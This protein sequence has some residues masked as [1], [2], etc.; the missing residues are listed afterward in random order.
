MVNGFRFHTIDHAQ[1][2]STMNYGVCVRSSCYNDTEYDF[3]GLL[4]EILEFQYCNLP[5]MYVTL[6]KCRWVD[7]VTGQRIH[8]K[9]GFVDV[10]LSRIYKTDEPFV[11]VQQATQVYYVG[12]PGSK[13]NRVDWIAA[14]TTKARSTVEV[15]WSDV[16]F[17]P[18]N[19]CMRGA[20]STQLDVPLLHDPSGDG[21]HIDS[22]ED[23]EADIHSTEGTDS[24]RD[25]STDSSPSG[26]ESDDFREECNV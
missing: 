3:Y 16:P 6:F 26:S 18:D 10:N 11:L 21:L 15:K 25:T 23:I 7:P 20:L 19:E 2:K 17:Q 4:E 24:V 8:P 5:N 14:C 12:Y 22:D 9:Y 13:R 1:D